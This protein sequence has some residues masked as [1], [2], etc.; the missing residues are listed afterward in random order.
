ASTRQANAQSALPALRD[1]EAKAAAA[2]YRLTL[3]LQ[4]LDREEA[5]AKDRIGELDLRLH[6]L[7]ADSERETRLAADAEAAI[8]KLAA[9]EETLRRE[10]QESAARRSGIAERVTEAGAALAAVEKVFADL[11]AQLADLTA[12]RNQFDS[13]VRDHGERATRLGDEIAGVE[14]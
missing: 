6:Q 11:T 1:A 4:E 13:A 3:A 10:T 9:E 8:A 2:L 5:R 14:R 7:A 12:R